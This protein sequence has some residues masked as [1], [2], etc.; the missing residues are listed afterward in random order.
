MATRVVLLI[1]L[2]AMFALGGWW[3]WREWRIDS[4][5]A[6]KGEWN[7]SAGICDPLPS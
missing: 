3:L 6:S 5:S 4:C 2:F 7:Q 1:I